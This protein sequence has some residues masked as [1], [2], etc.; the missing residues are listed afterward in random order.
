M[1]G[2]FLEYKL[3]QIPRELNKNADNLARLA[4]A[5]NSKLGWLILIELLSKPSTN[6]M[7]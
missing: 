4:F 1:L 6:V 7:E 5:T 2:Y 3:E